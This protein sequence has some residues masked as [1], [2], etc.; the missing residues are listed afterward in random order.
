M[1]CVPGRSPDLRLYIEQF[2]LRLFW[3]L[4]SCAPPVYRR[5]NMVSSPLYNSCQWMDNGIISFQLSVL[6]CAVLLCLSTWFDY[7]PFPTCC[8]VAHPIVRWSGRLSIS[9]APFSC[10]SIALPVYHSSNTVYHII[11][12]MPQQSSRLYRYTCYR[13]AHHSQA[14]LSHL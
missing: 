3:S 10:I 7:P 1:E 2:R 13:S 14:F 12:I 4:C 6:C 5:T 9:H 11:C 8:A